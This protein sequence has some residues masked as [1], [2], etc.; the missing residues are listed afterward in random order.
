MRK[1][2]VVI[3]L[4]IITGCDKLNLP[5]EV[6]YND[7]NTEFAEGLDEDLSLYYLTDA[8]AVTSAGYTIWV[9]GG[10]KW[11]AV[12]SELDTCLQYLDYMVGLHFR[13]GTRDS[14]GNIITYANP[15]EYDASW[16]FG[17]YSQV[18][19]HMREAATLYIEDQLWGNEFFNQQDVRDA[20]QALCDDI[21][22]TWNRYAELH[23]KAKAEWE[24]YKEVTYQYAYWKY[25][26]YDMANTEP[27]NLN[28]NHFEIRR[29]YK[30]TQLSIWKPRATESVPIESWWGLED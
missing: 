27:Y 13:K 10:R 23:E 20:V 14:H 3:L 18:S 8:D 6:L 16:T 12:H 15:G 19:D 22:E 21:E 11:S 17:G 30:D 7:E 1:L 29:Y 4:L 26:E 2:S 24:I 9:W 25:L 5:S 28:D